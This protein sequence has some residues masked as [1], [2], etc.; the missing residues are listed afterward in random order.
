MI[1]LQS[2]ERA[3]KETRTS[4]EGAFRFVLEEMFRTFQAKA[5]VRDVG[6]P[7]HHRQ[8]P[9]QQLAIAQAKCR[10]LESIMAVAGWERDDK[11]LGLIM[12]E[13]GDAANYLTFIAAL[14]SMLVE[15]SAQ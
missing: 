6:S 12:E 8:S 13:C 9:Q 3:F 2:E 10:R 15:E 5:K 1:Y 14:C 7:I 11:A 4:F